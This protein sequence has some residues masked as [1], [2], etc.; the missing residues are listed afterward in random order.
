MRESKEYQVFRSLISA[1]LRG[2]CQMVSLPK[3]VKDHSV[4][5]SFEIELK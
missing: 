5:A 2:L 1:Q 4:I 3:D